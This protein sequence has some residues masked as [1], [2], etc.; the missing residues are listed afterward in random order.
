[1]P[2]KK[3]LTAQE[4]R[5]AQLRKEIWAIIDLMFWG[6]SSPGHEP[7]EEELKQARYWDVAEAR[8]QEARQRWLALWREF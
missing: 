2:R 4:E 5:D 1:M 8:R 3:I 6:G 7:K